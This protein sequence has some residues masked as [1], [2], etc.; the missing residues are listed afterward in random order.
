MTNELYITVRNVEIPRFQ[1]EEIE[2]KFGA[3]LVHDFE[4]DL[5]RTLDRAL[6]EYRVTYEKDPDFIAIADRPGEIF[7]HMTMN[8]Q[9]LG[10]TLPGAYN[11]PAYFRFKRMFKVAKP[12]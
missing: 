1:I 6:R 11:K 7:K 10:L 8:I 2:Q 5:I 3:T 9:A 12:L 4:A